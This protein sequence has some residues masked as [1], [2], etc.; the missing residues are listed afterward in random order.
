MPKI[1]IQIVCS[2]ALVAALLVPGKA[3]TGDDR[4]PCPGI[5]NSNL[6]GNDTIVTGRIA[7]VELT[8]PLPPKC[9]VGQTCIFESGDS[10]TL[11]LDNIRLVQSSSNNKPIPQFLDIG[12][13][14][15][16]PTNPAPTMWD[17][18]ALVKDERLLL[19]FADSDYKKLTCV[20]D[21][22]ARSELAAQR[23]A[24]LKIISKPE[25][26]KEW[27]KALS[28]DSVSVRDAALDLLVRSS[29][30]DEKFLTYLLNRKIAEFRTAT[31]RRQEIFA[32]IV[33]QIHFFNPSPQVNKALVAFL[34][35]RVS[36]EDVKMKQTAIQTLYDMVFPDSVN[37]DPQLL[38]LA[39]RET[40][41]GTVKSLKQEIKNGS[42]APK[43][44]AL[45]R[46]LK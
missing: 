19:V 40:T 30:K 46:V 26:R 10:G 42:I 12:F 35:D 4:V 22:N 39:K 5:L 3:D 43:A 17:R 34:V 15:S 7:R 16:S 1:F 33:Y 20:G 44:E 41:S 32:N 36:D 18:L 14:R 25:Q 21:I 45:L 13:H 9:P 38:E 6:L 8:P 37:A 31:A 24:Q 29:A 23:I 28:D 27:L 11:E 2:A